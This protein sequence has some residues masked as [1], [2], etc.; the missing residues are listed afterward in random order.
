M[1]EVTKLDYEW[2]IESLDIHG[3]IIDH[4][5]KSSF[6]GPRDFDATGE[7]VVLVKSYARG[8]S[9]REDSFMIE[10]RTWAYL[11]DGKL[12]EEFEDGTRVPKRFHAEVARY[13]Q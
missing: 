12:P 4:D 1:R 6:P 2:D 10:D 7:V 8:L 9:G 3:D 13:R 5:F 11:E